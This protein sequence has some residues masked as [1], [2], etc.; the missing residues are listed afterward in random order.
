MKTT[1]DNNSRIFLLTGDMNK[2]FICNIEQLKECF[3]QFEDKDEISISHCYNNRFVKCS[4]KSIKDM[5][6]NMDLNNPLGLTDFKAKFTGRLDKAIG[7]TYKITFRAK[8]DNIED[9][10]KLLYSKYDCITDLK[11]FREGTPV[12][13]IYNPLNK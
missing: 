2:K 8:A 10:F 12:R 1:I 3:N 13:N 5:A 11:L 4:H 6:Y 9:F 7:K